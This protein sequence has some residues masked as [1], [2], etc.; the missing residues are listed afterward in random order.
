MCDTFGIK[1]S[2]TGTDGSIFGKNSDREPDETQVIVSCPANNHDPGEYLDCTYIKIPQTAYTNA[3][4]LSKPFWI[5]GAEMGVNAKGVVIGNEALFT[6]VKPEKK[7]GLIGMDLLR[8]G[9]ERGGSASE[10]ANVIIKLLKEHGQSG[11]CGYRDK[12]FSY[13][14]SF[15]L[16][17]R[18]NLLVLETVGRDYALKSYE[19]YATISNAIT[20]GKDWDE[21]SF[22]A[23]TDMKS[24]G[25]ILF[26]YFA[27]GLSR[28]KCNQNGIEL[29][30]GGITPI[31]AFDYLRTHSKSLAF[32]SSVCMHANGS[33]IRRSQTTGSMVVVLNRE[34]LFKI[35]VTAGSSPCV[36]SFK[37]VLPNHLPADIMIGGDGFDS[38]SFWWRH[39]RF[40][41]GALF[42]GKEYL[43]RIKGDIER[44]ESQYANI[45]FYKWD[46]DDQALIKASR[47]AFSAVED[48][49]AGYLKKI[50]SSRR[51]L[52][53]YWRRISDKNRI[54]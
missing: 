10:A 23:G 24:F 16:M 51:Y 5:W 25:D 39:E 47:D 36:T 4:L 52:T 21:S 48:M 41:L 46:T 29:G 8:L 50:D 12:S 22:P 14:N 18:D 44:L 17:D 13:M 1:M 42:A 26:T 9:L 34:G 54:P 32:N 40:H 45:P 37:P 11:S 53:S 33:L 28:R 2:W 43:P 19:S 27:G 38:S 7:A 31:K 49:E 35:F 15:L 6:K 30:R 20:L 3:V